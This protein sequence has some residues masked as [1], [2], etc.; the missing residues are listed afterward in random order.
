MQEYITL[1][2]KTVLFK[3]LTETE[4]KDFLQK[5][6]PVIKKYKKDSFI[7]NAGGEVTEICV[8]TQGKCHII[9][10]DLSGARNIVAEVTG[11]DIFAEALACAG[12]KRSPVAV[13]AV[14]DCS[15][16][17]LRFANLLTYEGGGK[18]KI[19]NNLVTLLAR[20]NVFL[21][22]KIEH[23][24]K[25]TIREKLLS[26]FYERKLESGGSKFSIPFSKTDLADF[27]FIDR[28]AMSRELSNMKKEGLIDF[29]G[30]FF[31]INK[32]AGY[33]D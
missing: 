8:L 23:I 13:R 11:G 19:L 20:K 6:Y 5:T 26:Y 14:M 25:R 28:S 17:M 12:V 16:L 22:N 2:K 31:I 3:N 7:I 29:D 4:I 32:K 15:V 1:L 24:C 9:K 21:N 10:E 33:I 18:N 27:L 30:S